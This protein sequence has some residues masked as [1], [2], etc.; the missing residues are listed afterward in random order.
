MMQAL[1]RADRRVAIGYQWSYSAAMARLKQE[2]AA[3][4]LGRP[5]RFRT[6]VSWPRNERYY[7]RNRWAGARRT[8]DGTWVLDSPVNNACAHHLHNMFYVLGARPDR[9]AMPTSVTAELYR[10]NAIQNYDTAALRCQ[11]DGGVELIF[12][13]SHATHEPRGP[14]F[15]YEFERG[16]VEYDE[17]GDGRV[18]AKLRGGV[19]LDYGS[20]NEAAGKK[21]FDVI[22][23]IRAGQ[24]VACG[25]EAASAQTLAMLAAQ[26]SP[27]GIVDFPAALVKVD[28]EPGQR[29]TR[30]SGLDLALDECY[31]QGRLPGEMQFPWARRSAAVIVEERP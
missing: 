12:I 4:T 3:G 6:Q 14:R 25:I 2:I 29:M 24:P 27:A 31:R 28:G 20:P 5:L 26:R 8:A 11:T 10:A 13:V 7:H 23:A 18:V 17:L 22:S 9:S 1:D 19:T 21:L 30:V 16:T 15:C